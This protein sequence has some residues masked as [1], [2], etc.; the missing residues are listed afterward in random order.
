MRIAT[1]FFSISEYGD[2]LTWIRISKRQEKYIELL[3]NCRFLTFGMNEIV[4]K[5]LSRFNCY[6]RLLGNVSLARI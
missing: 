2:R 4:F 5:G 1:P 3:R 6:V